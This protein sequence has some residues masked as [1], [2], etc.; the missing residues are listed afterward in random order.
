MG[1]GPAGGN[2]HKERKEQMHDDEEELCNTVSYDTRAVLQPLCPLPASAVGVC[3]AS[4]GAVGA[5]QDVV[6]GLRSVPN[7]E[8][9]NSSVATAGFFAV[10][11]VCICTVD[12]LLSTLN[13]CSIVCK[14]LTKCRLGN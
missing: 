13:C 14:L 6:H 11:S 8:L 12:H 2:V 3:S 9:L 4:A 10:C 7:P 5:T 1:A